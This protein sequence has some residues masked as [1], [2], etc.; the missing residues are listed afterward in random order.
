MSTCNFSS[1]LRVDRLIQKRYL[2]A[3]VHLQ[4]SPTPAPDAPSRGGLKLRPNR[5]QVAPSPRPRAS[6]T[7]PARRVNPLLRRKPSTEVIMYKYVFIIR[8]DTHRQM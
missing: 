6:V 1:L 8:I 5:L 7:P 3:E 2:K 4:S